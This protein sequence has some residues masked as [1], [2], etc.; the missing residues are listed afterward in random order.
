MISPRPDDKEQEP[1]QA[2]EVSDMSS[3]KAKM[4]ELILAM[5]MIPPR[6]FQYLSSEP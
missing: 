1:V 3:F 4:P 6:E 5:Y 2:A